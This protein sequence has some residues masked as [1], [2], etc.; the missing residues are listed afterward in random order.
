MFTSINQEG[1]IVNRLRSNTAL[2]PSAMALGAT[3]NTNLL[4][5]TGWRSDGSSAPP[6]ST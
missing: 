5:R 6:G 4:Y 2:F 3:A 1:G